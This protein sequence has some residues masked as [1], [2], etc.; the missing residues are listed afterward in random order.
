MLYKRGTAR[1]LFK[2]AEDTGFRSLNPD[3]WFDKADYQKTRVALGEI[4]RVC[5]EILQEQVEF[6]PIDDSPPP[7]E[8]IWVDVP[9]E[10]WHKQRVEVDAPF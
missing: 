7:P 10:P 6:R 2:Y 9:N 1:H 8:K 4:S 3:A 5:D